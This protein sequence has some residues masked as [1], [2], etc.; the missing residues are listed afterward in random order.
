MNKFSSICKYLLD[1]YH[2][3]KNIIG[4]M[5]FGS[6]IRGGYDKYSDVDI[7]VILS[8]K[9]EHSRENFIYSNKRLDVL[10]DTV[11]D[12]KTY[13]RAEQAN[14]RR[15]VSHMLAH[16]QILTDTSGQVRDLKNKASKNLLIK[17][18]YSSAEL[19]MHKY[20]IDDFWGEV[21]RDAKNKDSLAL[22]LDSQLLINNVIE[23]LCKLRGKYLRQPREMSGL[24]RELDKLWAGL[25][26]KFLKSG[27]LKQK[28]NLL[29]RII[30]RT[31]TLAGG[32]MPRHW[33][34]K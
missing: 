27:N 18:K 16:G 13:L 31:Y 34:I 30:R 10:F 24:L 22:A 21:Q 12:L 3:D 5:V 23:M 17:T 2:S 25:I 33:S 29:S 32:P 7:Y 20:S 28:L 14:I 15:P 11:A 19:L 4:C 6:A 1:R 9:Q 8:K 26:V